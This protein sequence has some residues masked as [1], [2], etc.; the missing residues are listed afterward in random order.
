MRI[1]TDGTETYSLPVASRLLPRSEKTCLYPFGARMR[2][3]RS[4]FFGRKGSPTGHLKG[5]A[6][7]G[8][9]QGP[10]C[11]IPL[12]GVGALGL[13]LGWT[14]VADKKRVAAVTGPAG[15]AAGA[16]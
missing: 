6:R 12:P 7:G 1:G 3:G 11:K 13:G 4:R 14:R 10:P 8:G 5:G 9:G 2:G 16:C 15:V